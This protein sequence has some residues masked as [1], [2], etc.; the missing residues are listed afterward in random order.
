MGPFP[1]CE[2][3][4]PYI[5]VCYSHD[6]SVVV[7]RDLSWLNDLGYRVWYDEGIPAGTEWREELAQRIKG[8]SIFL[9]FVSPRSVDSAHCRREVNFALDERIPMLV[10]HL[11]ETS[12][13]DGLRLALG[14]RQAVLRYQLAEPRYRN[15]LESSVTRHLQAQPRPAHDSRPSRVARSRAIKVVTTGLAMLVLALGGWTVW[16]RHTHPTTRAAIPL[17]SDGEAALPRPG[18]VVEER[19]QALPG[20][21]QNDPRTIAVSPF[22]APSADTGLESISQ[23]LNDDINAAFAAFRLPRV[24]SHTPTINPKDNERDVESV[25]VGYVLE[26]SVRPTSDGVRIT[27]ELIRTKDGDHV[28]SEQYDRA[29]D[30]LEKDTRDV[31][32]VIVNAART[33]LLSD[34]NDQDWLR[35]PGDIKPAA[36]ETYLRALKDYRNIVSGRGGSWSLFSSLLDKATELDPR[37]YLAYLTIAGEGSTFRIGWDLPV[38]DGRRRAYSALQRAFEIRPLGSDADGVLTY[39]LVLAFFDM[40][41]GSARAAFAQALAK[42]PEASPAA[43]ALGFADLALGRV[44]EAQEA[45]GVASTTLTQNDFEPAESLFTTYGVGL[46]AFYAGDFARSRD[47]WRKGLELTEDHQLSAFLLRQIASSELKLGNRKEAANLIDRAWQLAGASNPLMFIASFEGIGRDARAILAHA[48][49]DDP[50]WRPLVF[51]P[52]LAEAAM[53]YLALG[54]V[55]GVVR[56][57]R[58]AIDERNVWLIWSLRSSKIWDPIRAD[59]RFV[60]LMRYLERT[61]TDARAKGRA[62]RAELRM[63][64]PP[65]GADA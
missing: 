16:T 39:G 54:D 2:G 38:D 6:D 63:P 26:G 31:A 52:N 64:D 33:W 18:S 21:G 17:Q 3:T 58:V 65:V 46:C 40:D 61:E 50:A 41:Y 29:R 57:L 27:V 8:A 11:Q 30:T 62:V 10:V 37:F 55:D 14:D 53:A 36:L 13:P 45:C 12:L 24:A 59:Q 19:V 56:W 22:A 25:N 7:Y 1:A 28:W 4:A 43:M 48:S 60:D 47:V 35:Q 51:G 20:A 49:P 15:L 42:A 44:N 23:A 9:F 5:F 32:R 34:A